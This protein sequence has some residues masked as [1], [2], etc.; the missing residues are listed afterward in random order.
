VNEERKGG[1]HMGLRTILTDNDPALR[2]PSRVVTNFDRRLHDLLDDLAE[3]LEN[4]N[5]A[6]LAAPQVGVLRRVFI[7]KID[8]LI[9]LVNPRLVCSEGVQEGAEGCLSIPG[10]SGYVKRPD[11]VTV[12][13]QDRYGKPVVM[14]GEGFLARAFCHELDHLD[15]MLY[16][17]IMERFLTVEEIAELEKEE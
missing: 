3:T 14:E 7:V 6:G 10:K 8:E 16:T 15:G 5:G 4:A 1:V 2:K 17:D 11:H 9:E 12:E 13:A